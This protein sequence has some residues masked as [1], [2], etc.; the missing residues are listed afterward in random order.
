MGELNEDA[1]KIVLAGTFASGKAT[2]INA[3]VEKKILHMSIILQSKFHTKILFGAEQD[4]ATIYYKDEEMQSVVQ[5][6]TVDQYLSKASYYMSEDNGIHVNSLEI[7][8]RERFLGNIAEVTILPGL[9]YYDVE[10]EKSNSLLKA[11]DAIVF[12]IIAPMA[13]T[14]L[15][16]DFIN[17]NLRNSK[18]VFFVLTKYDFIP[19]KDRKGFYDTCKLY[20]QKLFVDK[21]G[22]FD[23]DLYKKRVFFINA[24]GAYC[25]R[26]GEVY[27][28]YRNGKGV[29]LQITDEE[30]GVPQFERS[31]KEFL[32][33]L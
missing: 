12:T 15:E 33:S 16:K 27:K 29:A 17:S 32:D 2:L 4:N 19:L 30:T 22:N 5:R 13:F 10:N 8:Q 24:N 11:A 1:I 20:L 14:A 26:T 28:E 9:N 6:M 23:E 18:N 21:S 31:L 3:L 7:R 25:A